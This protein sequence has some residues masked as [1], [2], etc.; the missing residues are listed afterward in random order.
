MYII[1]TDN[2]VITYTSSCVMDK[3]IVVFECGKEAV[4]ES[5]ILKVD[6]SRIVKESIQG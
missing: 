1:L 5:Q 3:N 2:S 6:T 4:K